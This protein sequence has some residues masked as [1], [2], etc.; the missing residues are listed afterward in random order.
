MDP[1]TGQALY[2]PHG[3]PAYMTVDLFLSQDFK[4]SMGATSVSVGVRNVFDT[5]PRRV[6]DS[7]L[8][9]ADPAYD[10]VG[11]FFYAR[12]ARRL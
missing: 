10:F 7:F 8:T 3:V 11:R 6:Y 4:T 1:N 5:F 2:S 9:Y 12:V